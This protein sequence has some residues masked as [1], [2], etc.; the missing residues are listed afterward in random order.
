M[1]IDELNLQVVI[2][3]GRLSLSSRNIWA[4]CGWRNENVE[5]KRFGLRGSVWWEMR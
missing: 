1:M 3:G 5:G 4:W 2:C